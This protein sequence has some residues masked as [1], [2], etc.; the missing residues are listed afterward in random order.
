ME[1]QE[2]L[3]KIFSHNNEE[4]LGTYALTQEGGGK[5]MRN[6]TFS[7]SSRYVSF[8]NVNDNPHETIINGSNENSFCKETKGKQ[9]SQINLD[10]KNIRNSVF[11][12]GSKES[13]YKSF[14]NESNTNIFSNSNENL[15]VRG[16]QDEK[17]DA[18][19]SVLSRE[20]S[21]KHYHNSV[22]E[23]LTQVINDP[24]NNTNNINNNFLE[25]NNE[26]QDI[27]NTLPNENDSSCACKCRLI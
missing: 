20:G 7:Q 14:M 22:K 27:F 16:R 9:L 8:V 17:K 4:F 10:E 3:N 6:S 25:N 2:N 13:K 1:E 11:S 5:N 21:V 24:K 26:K 19:Y 15:I 18:F 23:T 12:Q